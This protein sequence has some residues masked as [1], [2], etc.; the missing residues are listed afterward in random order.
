MTD[1]PSLE[2]LRREID[3]LQVET[4]ASDAQVAEAVET[5]LSRQRV[6][7]PFRETPEHAETL[8]RMAWWMFVRA[9]ALDLRQFV[10]SS[11]ALDVVQDGTRSLEESID[12]LEEIASKFGLDSPAPLPVDS[13]EARQIQKAFRRCATP[14]ESIDEMETEA[15]QELVTEAITELLEREELFRELSSAIADDLMGQFD[16]L[17][18][19]GEFD[20]AIH[21]SL[22]EP[23][24]ESGPHHQHDY[25]ELET[26]AAYV[27]R[28][29]E[30]YEEGDVD[31][32]VEDYT[33]A[34]ELDPDHPSEI[35]HRRGVSKAAMEE[36][37]GAI[38]DFSEALELDADNVGA[39]VDRGL[40]HYDQDNPQAA[41]EDY[42]RALEATDDETLLAKVYAN[43]GVARFAMGQ[44]QDAMEDFE[45]AMDRDDTSPAPYL[46]RAKV[47]RANRDVAGAMDDYDRALE[48]DP[49]CADAYAARGFLKLQQEEPEDAIEDLSEAIELRPYDAMTHYNRGN[50]HAMLEHFQ[51]AIEDYDEAIE[52]DP[53]DAQA[54]TNRGS[55]KMKLEDFNGAIDDW[56]KAIEIDPYDPSPYAKRGALWNMLDQEDEAIE[57]LNRALEVAPDD[58]PLE[59]RVRHMLQEIQIG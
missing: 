24:E 34:L 37:E 21:G 27:E 51:Q 45:R 59:Q 35:Y 9:P 55:A 49:E 46:N 6:V 19:E 7:E 18:Q 42:D 29:D 3:R 20:D 44:S 53:D 41:L 58:W 1:Q 48:V 14:S 33:A 12:D 39:L 13:P 26:A 22:V 36:T 8:W 2:T 17:A 4:G 57:D 52:L 28:A 32:A 16:D 56:D 31:G 38:E 47:R 30:R 11:M 5:I 25:E 10:Y 54:Y 40:A 15:I 43:R 23:E 50:A